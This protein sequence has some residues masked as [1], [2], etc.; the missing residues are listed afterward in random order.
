MKNSEYSGDALIESVRNV[1]FSQNGCF[2]LG[3]TAMTVVVVDKYTRVVL[4]VIAVL[5]SLVAGL[6]A[7]F[8]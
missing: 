1:I 2:Q 7:R 6:I 4:T 8:L 5:L 3:E